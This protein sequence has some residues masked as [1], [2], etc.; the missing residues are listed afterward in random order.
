[1]KWPIGGNIAAT[2]RRPA[3]VADGYH[4]LWHSVVKNSPHDNFLSRMATRV[5]NGC[6]QIDRHPTVPAA[7]HTG[8]HAQDAGPVVKDAD[9][10]D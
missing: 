7:K 2:I 10:A 1:V 4:D 3:L 8:W 5:V 6:C 9:G